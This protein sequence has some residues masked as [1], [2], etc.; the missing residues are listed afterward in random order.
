MSRLG[1]AEK[2]ENYRDVTGWIER[3]TP[4]TDPQRDVRFQR[5]VV[6]AR[7]AVEGVPTWFAIFILK[8]ATKL[9]HRATT[10]PKSQPKSQR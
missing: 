1:T 7:Q 5:V 4:D 2:S 8:R 6:T 3:P 9:R 10:L